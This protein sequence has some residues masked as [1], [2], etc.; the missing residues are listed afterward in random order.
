MAQNRRDVRRGTWLHLGRAEFFALPALGWRT[1]SGGFRNGLRVS[2][3]NV[4]YSTRSEKRLTFE[5]EHEEDY[6]THALLHQ[7]GS[8]VDRQR[9]Y[10]GVE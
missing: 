9:Q 5:H 10:D 7:A 6:K 4:G 1:S 8:Y 3:T 2:N